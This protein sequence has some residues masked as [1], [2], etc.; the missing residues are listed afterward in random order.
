MIGITPRMT[1][2]EVVGHGRVRLMFSD[3]LSGEID[4]LPRLSGPVF[5]SV[6][7]EEGFARAF[8]DTEARTIAWPGEVDLD[9]DVLYERVRTGRWYDE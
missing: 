7:T 9:P 1:A 2:V 5:D 4:L 3:G 6:R 8:L